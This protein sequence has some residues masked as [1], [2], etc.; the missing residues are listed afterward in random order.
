MTPMEFID[1]RDA[2]VPASGFQSVQFRELEILLGLPESNRSSLGGCTFLSAFNTDHEEYLKKVMKKTSLFEAVQN[3]LERT[4][5]TECEDWDFWDEY[6]KAV[7]KMTE[8]DRYHI[9]TEWQGMEVDVEVEEKKKAISNVEHKFAALFDPNLYNE[10]KAKG[11]FRLS[12][13]AMKSALL[14]ELYRHEPIFH[15]PFEF[16]EAIVDFDQNMSLFR[17]SHATMVHRMIG[18]RM[19]TGGSSG[20]YYLR[21][22]TG[23]R[24]KVFNDLINISTFMI[25]TA[26]IPPIPSHWKTRMNFSMD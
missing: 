11:H 12:Q 17:H 8:R 6:Q 14:I 1:F 20:V 26:E 9:E 5:F 3:W 19:G 21:S 25:P 18:S 16:L 24:Y 2:L 4:P 22:T 15:L 23:L 10:L 13:K 7:N